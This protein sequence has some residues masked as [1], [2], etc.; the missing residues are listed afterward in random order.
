M[1]NYPKRVDLWN[2]YLDLEISGNFPTFAR[3][4]FERVIKMKFSTK[5]MKFFFKKYL[6]FEKKFGNEEQQQHVKEEA[7]KYVEQLNG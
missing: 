4:I 6:E 3:R 5:K 7:M 1:S 2:V